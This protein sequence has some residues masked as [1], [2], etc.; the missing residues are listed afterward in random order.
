MQ[1]ASVRRTGRSD[2]TPRYIFP[3][4]C[5]HCGRQAAQAVTSW[6]DK[7][8]KY[9]FRFVDVRKTLLALYCTAQCRSSGM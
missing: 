9:P 6:Q 4:V 3:S 8:A 5:G 2:R 1:I 7:N